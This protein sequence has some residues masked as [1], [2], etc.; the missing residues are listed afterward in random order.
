MVELGADFLFA[1][2]A[3]VENRVALHLGM[4]NLD[5]NLAA[6]EK[7]GGAEDG[8]HAA[9]GHQG[10]DAVVIELVPG[11]EGCHWAAPVSGEGGSESGLSGACKA[12]R[13]TCPHVRRLERGL[14]AG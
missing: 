1:L 11:M 6:G 4:R 5:G 13:G 7:V 14:A 10:V 2:E 8:G 12:V 9:A 3:L